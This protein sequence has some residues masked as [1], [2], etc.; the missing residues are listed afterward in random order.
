MKR[1]KEAQNKRERMM[2]GA[3]AREL[4][5]RFW[6]SSQLDH[7]FRLP[8]KGPPATGAASTAFTRRPYSS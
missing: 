8:K 2:M 1:S 6:V 3:D 4:Y 7:G 5:S